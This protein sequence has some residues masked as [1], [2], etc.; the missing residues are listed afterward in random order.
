MIVGFLIGSE[1][2][3]RFSWF[4]VT[5]GVISSVFVALHGSFVKKILANVNNNEWTLAKYNTTMSVIIMLPFIWISGELNSIMVYEPENW[6]AVSLMVL[7]TGLLGFGINIAVFLQIKFTSPLTSVIVGAAKSVIQT[8][9]SILIF[10]NPISLVVI[11]C[12]ALGNLLNLFIECC[13]SYDQFI[14]N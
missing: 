5:F 4:G 14:W 10:R 9:L 8:V 7:G 13:W 12:N 6:T 11:S 3:V 2:E 1:G